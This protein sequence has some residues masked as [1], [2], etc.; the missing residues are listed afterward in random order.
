MCT[1]DMFCASRFLNANTL[2]FLKGKKKP[3]QNCKQLFLKV[4]SCCKSEYRQLRV[5]SEDVDKG[6]DEKM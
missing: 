6:E 5:G 2:L 3:S 4:S 1:W